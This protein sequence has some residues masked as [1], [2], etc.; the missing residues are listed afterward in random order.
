MNLKDMAYHAIVG[1]D[2][3]PW[4]VSGARGLLSA[5]IFAGIAF[6]N[7]WAQTDDIKLLI[8]TP[9]TVFLGT[10]IVRWGLEG[11]IATK[12]NGGSNG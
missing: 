4:V 12:K 5:A 1:N 9:G 10:L 8:S 7:I 11:I 6:F 3:P 2:T